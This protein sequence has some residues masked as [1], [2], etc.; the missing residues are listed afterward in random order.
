MI[1]QKVLTPIMQHEMVHGRI[2]KPRVMQRFDN[3]LLVIFK[4]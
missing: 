1:G 3:L 2:Q 4:R